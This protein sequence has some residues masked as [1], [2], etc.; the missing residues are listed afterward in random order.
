MSDETDN[1]SSGSDNFLNSSK[2]ADNA[3]LV[4]NDQGKVLFSN[5]LC[6]SNFSIFQ[7]QSVVF[8]LEAGGI[9]VANEAGADDAQGQLIP[10][11]TINEV[12]YF[13]AHCFSLVLD[14]SHLEHRG[15]ELSSENIL[16]SDY[17]NMPGAIYRA[18][19]DSHLTITQVTNGIFT[20][21]GYT[22]EDLVN[23]RK[24][25][26]ADLIHPDDL[27]RVHSSRQEALNQNNLY[28]VVYRIRHLNGDYHTVRDQGRALRSAKGELQ[29]MEGW[30]L[31]MTGERQVEEELAES[32]ARY[33]HLIEASP[34]AVVYA[35]NQ[36]TIKLANPQFSRMLEIDE[37]VDLVGTN[38]LQFLDQ[39]NDAY[40]ENE[41]IQ[42]L[43]GKN[44]HKG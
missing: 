16:D 1:H 22:P 28:E 24:V 20:M 44:A 27:G 13:G 7:E 30:L 41:M 23:N 21:I 32:E 12:E 11:S 10:Y 40:A 4:V 15:T 43:V 29:Y 31:P 38:V 35:D 26:F 36:G 6:Q 42:N 18:F 33:R 25:A 37:N 9:R 14:T 8:D 39:H 17:Q 2:S 19:D 34:D 3:V 5:P